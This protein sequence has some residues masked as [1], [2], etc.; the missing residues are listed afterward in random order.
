VLRPLNCLSK[1]NPTNKPVEE[2]N[3]LS[4]KTM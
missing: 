3:H 4:S 1:L 2:K